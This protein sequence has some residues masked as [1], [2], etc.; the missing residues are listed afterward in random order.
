MV[1]ADEAVVP[2]TTMTY[3]ERSLGDALSG[4]TEVASSVN[5]ETLIVRFV[6]IVNVVAACPA[7]V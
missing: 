4:K 5:E 7:V 2:M 3:Q 6:E 1:L